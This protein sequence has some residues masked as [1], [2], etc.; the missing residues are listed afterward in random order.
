MTSIKKVENY[1]IGINLTNKFHVRTQSL[2]KCTAIM[3]PLYE[4]NSCV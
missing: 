4:N 2:I 3:H 1:L